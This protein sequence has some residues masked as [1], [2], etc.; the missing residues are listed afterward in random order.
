MSATERVS[1]RVA[2]YRNVVAQ[3]GMTRHI[4]V[5]EVGDTP[6]GPSHRWVVA[7]QADGTTLVGGMDRGSFRL[8]GQYAD[9][10]T[11]F[12]D[13]VENFSLPAPRI[14]PASALTELRQA[15][16][17]LAS[18]LQAE[19]TTR[20][21]TAADF[22]VGTAFDSMGTASDHTLFLLDS[23][24]DQRSVPPTDLAMRRTGYY[25][26]KPFPRGT[27]VGIVAPWFGQPGGGVMVSLAST[28]A[29]HVSNGYLQPFDVLN[30]EEDY[31]PAEPSS[32]M[33]D[34][35]DALAEEFAR[36]QIAE[37]LDFRMPHRTPVLPGGRHAII[38]LHAGEVSVTYDEGGPQRRL[39]TGKTVA[40]ISDMAWGLARALRNDRWIETQPGR[41]EKWLAEHPEEVP[42]TGKDTR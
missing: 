13:L 10:P 12:T 27:D 19:A 2:N 18:R 42:A 14:L 20:A 4:D 5:L 23:P 15:A 30:T 21:L 37:G 6:D 33:R 17:E 28:I 9:D 40:E 34:E 25:L 26:A 38:R 24:L 3:F 7:P 39:A 1:D 29:P 31:G 8:L 36:H 16:E 32:A 11:S 22:P 41:Y 35:L